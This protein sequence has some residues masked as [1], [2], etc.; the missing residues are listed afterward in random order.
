[1]LDMATWFMA[2]ELHDAQDRETEVGRLLEVF[3]ATKHNGMSDRLEGVEKVEQLPVAVSTAITDAISSATM[4][5][6][7]FARARER[8]YGKPLRVAFLLA[9]EVEPNA[10]GNPGAAGDLGSMEREHYHSVIGGQIAMCPPTIEELLESGRLD[11][12]LPVEIEAIVERASRKGDAP[13]FLWRLLNYLVIRGGRARIHQDRL[14]LLAGTTHPRQLRRFKRAGIDAGLFLAS[15][16]AV[17]MV[18]S[19]SYE[20][21]DRVLEACGL[22]LQ[23]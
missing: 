22:V 18:R 5:I 8:D 17:R 19:T 23:L 13:R 14:L 3:C 10:Y 4:E 11:Q 21:T 7:K 12:S 16:D 9:G 2:V 6:G 1:L 20:L 15:E